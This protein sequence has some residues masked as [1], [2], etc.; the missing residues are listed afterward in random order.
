MPIELQKSKLPINVLR[1]RHY[2]GLAYTHK[3]KKKAPLTQTDQEDALPIISIVQ[4]LARAQ[5]LVCQRQ[6]CHQARTN[7]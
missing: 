7:G 4:L 1:F 3:T 6:P 2:L 5:S